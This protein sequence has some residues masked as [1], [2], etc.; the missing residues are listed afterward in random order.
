M[1][2]PE[3]LELEAIDAALAG[4]YVAPEHAELADL[5]LL[6][7][8]ERPQPAPAW[9]THLDRR[10]EAGFPARP[11]P[12]R[13]WRWLRQVAP[14][15]AIVAIV[16]PIVAIGALRDSSN[17]SGSGGGGSSA[18]SSASEAAGDSATGTV[19][20]QVA[21]RAAAPPNAD[22]IHA[23]KVEKAA[24]LTLAAPRRDID[25]VAGEVSDVASALGGF[26]SSS[27][28]SSSSGGD[29]QLH[30]P[31]TRLDTTIQR[32]SKLGKVRDLSRDTRDITSAVVS[33]R[34]RLKDARA[35]RKSLLKQLANAT[36]LDET[37]KLRARLRVVSREIA[38]ARN[39]LA[40]VNNRADFANVSVTLVATR[41]SAGGGVWT[42]ADAFHDALRVLEV[43]AGV[44]LI[45]AAIAL[46][47]LVAW[48][49]G[50]FAR[51]S[52]TRRRRERAL[53]MA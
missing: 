18:S 44:L 8:D 47:L 25:R 5:A 35:E 12:R 39:A 30:V 19:T 21:P 17:D 37:A 6:L 2:S 38:A 46:P 4:H 50:W 3:T 9:A 34:D 26:V 49:L 45:A 7:R 29:V 43:V 28:V 31:S 42:P 27:S 14:V 1:T 53:D 48:L 11:K 16:V 52:V 20:D 36:T 24:Q 15:V 22:L 23:R 40:R 13:E 10:V 51:R 33:A 41:N 32:L